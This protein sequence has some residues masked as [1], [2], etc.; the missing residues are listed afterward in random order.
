MDREVDGSPEKSGR[1][2]D[3]DGVAVAVAVAEARPQRF[4]GET[5]MDH[6]TAAAEPADEPGGAGQAATAPNAEGDAIG[7]LAEKASQPL[8]L[9]QADSVSLCATRPNCPAC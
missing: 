1:S 7:T 2:A 5:S 3:L 8:P 6:P 9:R 4:G